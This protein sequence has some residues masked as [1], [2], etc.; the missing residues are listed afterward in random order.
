M[1][2]LERL[3]GQ[4][5]EAPSAAEASAAP[6]LETFN[7]IK[8]TKKVTIE[9]LKRFIS[10]ISELKNELPSDLVKLSVN[11]RILSRDDGEYKSLPE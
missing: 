10:N 2:E 3:A 11:T 8:R 4:G 6:L 9:L 5:E 7:T 1:V